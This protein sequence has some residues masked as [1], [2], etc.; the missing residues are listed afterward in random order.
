ESPE[1]GKYT[2]NS[3]HMSTYVNYFAQASVCG[4]TPENGL[5]N[6]GNCIQRQAFRN[7]LD[8]AE[9]PPQKLF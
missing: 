8:V 4:S 2:V 3:M 5:G 1:S 9:K 6:K 7:A